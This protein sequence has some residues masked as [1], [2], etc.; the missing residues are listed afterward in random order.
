MR[1][2]QDTN[3]IYAVTVR[4]ETG[5][6]VVYVNDSGAIVQAPAATTVQTVKT[7]EPAQSTQTTQTTTQTTTESQEATVG[8]DQIQKD[9]PRYELLEKKGKKEIYLDII[10]LGRRSQLN[11]KKTNFSRAGHYSLG[12][13]PSGALHLH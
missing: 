13:W 4:G 7:V 12:C 11:G 9:Q 8:Y 2:V 10:R 3:G 5:E 1:V 6:Q